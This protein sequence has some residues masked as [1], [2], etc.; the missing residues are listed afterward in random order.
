MSY[1]PRCPS[2]GELFGNRLLIYLNKVNELENNNM[3]NEE[4]DKKKTEIVK[5]L[6]FDN[7]CCMM[8]ML[9]Y[10]KELPQYIK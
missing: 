6:G 2:C 7:W 9:C 1:Y 5:N 3:T 10:I 8:K 4:I